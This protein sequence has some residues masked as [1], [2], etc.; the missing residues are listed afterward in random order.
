[1]QEDQAVLLQQQREAI[2]QQVMQSLRD[3][4]VV[5]APA[6]DSASPNTRQK[7]A[8]FPSRTRGSST[9]RLEQNLHSLVLHSLSESGLDFPHVQRPV[10]VDPSETRKTSGTQQRLGLSIRKPIIVSRLEG[11]SSDAAAGCT[12]AD[13]S[14]YDLVDDGKKRIAVTRHLQGEK[15]SSQRCAAIRQSPL[16]AG[17]RR[18]KSDKQRR[19]ARA[20]ISQNQRRAGGNSSRALDRDD[21]EAYEYAQALDPVDAEF[22][23]VRSKVG[24]KT[25][26][27]LEKSKA[28]LSQTRD[29]KH[30][31]NST[32][33]GGKFVSR[34]REMQAD[35]GT[36][37]G[38]AARLKPADGNKTQHEEAQISRDQSTTAANRSEDESAPA[39][40]DRE[41]VPTN[42]ARVRPS[43]CQLRAENQQ[44]QQQLEKGSEGVAALIRCDIDLLRPP[45]RSPENE[46]EWE[47]ELARQIL[48]IYATSVK[49]KAAGI[50][51]GAAHA[52]M[53]AEPGGRV[54][55]RQ[56]PGSGG[57]RAI[58]AGSKDRSLGLS[59]SLPVLTTNSRNSSTTPGTT[60][61]PQRVSTASV[62]YSWE[63]SQRLQNGKVVINMPKVPRPIW[64]AGTGAV[65]AVWCAL[66]QGFTDLQ[67]QSQPNSSVHAGGQPQ[68]H[69]SPI[70]M[71]EHRLCEEVRRMEAKQQFSLCVTT[72]ESLL[73]SL[74]RARGVD[75]LEI[76][77]WKQL[78]VTC[79]AFASRCI[80]YKKFT[81]ALQLIKQAEQLIHNSI[82]VDDTTRFELL[83][84]L[85]DTYAHYYYRKQKPHAGLQYILKAHEI[86]SKQSNWSHLAKCRLHIAN[87]LSFQL[88]HAVAMGYM[89]SILEMIEENKLEEQG[90]NGDGASA[91]KICMAAVCYN[92]LAVEQLHLREFE[93]ASVSSANAKRLARLCLS[94]SNRWLVQFEAT[95]NCA[96]LA[97]ATLM[98]DANANKSAVLKTNQKNRIKTSDAIAE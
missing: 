63:P 79:N 66:A 54:T 68:R 44:M 45:E 30:K 49:A 61:R 18:N 64:F 7:Y 8:T 31:Q 22:N 38:T 37:T 12:D 39:A 87:L 77:L 5:A 46:H 50:E 57:N 53:A 91:Q 97:I 17:S 62:H 95:S 89:A 10:Y 9:N 69:P 92:N 51:S 2:I 25:L 32:T 33:G 81:V 3:S 4:G 74:V 40:E 29:T 47:N 6:S 20:K 43:S 34:M 83:A 90:E 71:C 28:L 86:H 21:S 93:A 75:D 24:H 41:F 55:H 73:I 84:Y 16:V 96:G 98:E 82:L 65:K 60:T 59:C 11:S 56:R 42:S 72:L 15:K 80:D 78:V 1:M 19:K 35:V 36:T 23:S 58:G 88:K 94:Y 26:A 14:S 67:T 48:T 27:I 52:A 85:Y 70:A 13:S 76:K